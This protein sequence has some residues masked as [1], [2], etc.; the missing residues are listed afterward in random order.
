MLGHKL[1]IA[2]AP[3]KGEDFTLITQDFKTLILPGITHWQ[4]PQ[5]FAYFPSNSTFESMIGEF[6]ASSVSN[7]GFSWICSPACTELEQVVLDWC[8]KMFGLEDGFLL[9]SKTGGGII[10]VCLPSVSVI[11]WQEV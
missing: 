5:F 7:P 4:H 11:L 1:T 2:S 6:L 10:F 3:E 8:A 9:S